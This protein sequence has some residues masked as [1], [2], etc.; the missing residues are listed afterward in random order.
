MSEVLI[1]KMFRRGIHQI[2]T[3]RARCPDFGAY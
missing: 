2:V 1:G 3:L